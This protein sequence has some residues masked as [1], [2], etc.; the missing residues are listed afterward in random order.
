MVEQ[1]GKDE[2][3]ERLGVDTTGGGDDQVGILQTEPLHEGTDAGR[4]G[5]YPAQLRRQL[6]EGARL[7]LRKVEENLRLT[8]EAV[9]FPLL[10]GIAP[11]GGIAVIRDV[12]R[13]RHQIGTVDQVQAVRERARDPLDMLR[14]QGRCQH[15]HDAIARGRRNTH[16][17]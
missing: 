15:D 10:R 9:P 1:R 3:G 14:F 7:V 11:P 16:G 2:L 13:R 12:A 5:L 8:Q 4:R 17:R 6:Q